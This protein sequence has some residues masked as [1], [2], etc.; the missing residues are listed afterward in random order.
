MCDVTYPRLT[1]HHE[2]I[3]E[4]VHIY[5]VSPV[6]VRVSVTNTPYSVLLYVSRYVLTV[7]IVLGFASVCL[8]KLNACSTNLSI[9]KVAQCAS[10]SSTRFV[11]R[12]RKYLHRSMMRSLNFSFGFTFVLVYV[13]QATLDSS[14]SENF[15]EGDYINSRQLFSIKSYGRNPESRYP[16]GR[17][18]GD[19]DNDTHCKGSLVCYFRV[20]GSNAP[21]PGCYGGEQDGS[22]TDYCVDPNDLGGGQKTPTYTSGGN[23]LVLRSYGSSPPPSYKPLGECEGDCD[24]DRD[25]LAGLMCYQRSSYDPVPGCFGVDAG[26]TDYCI[27]DSSISSS[28]SSS[29]S[30]GPYVTA[31]S[32]RLKLYWEYGY[33]WQEETFERKW[34]ILCSGGCNYGSQLYIDYCDTR[35]SERFDFVR[36]RNNEEHLIQL[37]RANLCLERVHKR[38]YLYPCDSS[39]KY[40]RW[41]ARSGD[42]GGSRFEISQYGFSDYCMTQHHH[43]KPWERVGLEP[44]RLARESQTSY[45][46]PY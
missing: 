41:Y 25:C 24:S 3:I 4:H 28:S 32:F 17:C 8:H 35:H 38:I 9:G 11:N 27:K 5:L 14:E 7:G 1:L 31:N 13:A 23:L 42:F 33:Y 19:C 36:L 44:C 30:V 2:N 10:S 43:P 12:N 16:L 34:C 46:N 40:Q 29:S 6:Y 26:R 45:W 21:V 20:E 22:R 37:E 18:E 15:I 39:S